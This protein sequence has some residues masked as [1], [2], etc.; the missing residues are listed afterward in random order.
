MVI[1]IDRLIATQAVQRIAKHSPEYDHI[2]AGRQEAEG[3]G[4][5]S[6]LPVKRT[7]SKSKSEDR[8]KGLGPKKQKRRKEVKN[9]KRNKAKQRQ[10]Q[11]PVSRQPFFRTAESCAVK[12]GTGWCIC[13]NLLGSSCSCFAWLVQGISLTYFLFCRCDV[14]GTFVQ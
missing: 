12:K 5:S 10:D 11:R 14:T 13:P 7:S 8:I 2:E 1:E 6:T 3:G 4:S 9:K